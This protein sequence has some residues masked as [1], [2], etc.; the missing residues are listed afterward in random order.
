M[1]GAQWDVD[2]HRRAAAGGALAKAVPV[3]ALGHAGMTGMHQ[4]NHLGA[5]VRTLG[6]DIDPVR[7][8][9]TGT[10]VLGTVEQIVVALGADFGQHFPKLD[11]A[12]FGPAIAH[13]FARYK[14][15]KPGPAFRAGRGIEAVFDKGKMAAQGLR[16]IRIGL[17]QFNQQ[18]EQLG[19]GSTGTAVLHRHPHRAKTC[20]LEPAHG[21][22][23]QFAS[24]FTADIAGGDLAKQRAEAI[25]QGFVVGAHGQR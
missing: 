21:F 19:D 10:V 15:C 22:I 23:G 13:Q 18:L 1:L 14:A 6:I 25:G 17:G 20:L 2:I 9:A 24:L 12:D 4:G 5:V 16:N 7:E 11:C 8:D 3:I